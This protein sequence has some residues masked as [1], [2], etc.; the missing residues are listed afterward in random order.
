MRFYAES[1]GYHLLFSSNDIL[2]AIATA[3][4]Y[5]GDL[6]LV[7]NGTKYSDIK[8][9]HSIKDKKLIFS[10]NDPTCCD[11]SEYGYSIVLDEGENML[12]FTNKEGKLQFL[13]ELEPLEM[14]WRD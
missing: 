12:G 13:Y 4:N 8:K 14:K 2:K 10:S 1:N 5:C 9:W 3:D 6:W 11:V 7:P